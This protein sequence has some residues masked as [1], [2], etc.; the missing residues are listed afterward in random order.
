MTSWTHWEWNW[1]VQ[2]PYDPQHRFQLRNEF[3]M[4]SLQHFWYQNLLVFTVW[5]SV[6][7]HWWGFAVGNKLLPFLFGDTHRSHMQVVSVR[8]Y[9]TLCS[10]SLDNQLRSFMHM[11]GCDPAFNQ[12]TFHSLLAPSTELWMNDN[13]A[14]KAPLR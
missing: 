5:C 6:C 1:S 3:H 2:I 9:I 14:T 12:H 4:M 13:W 8:L 11:N 7:F 10:K